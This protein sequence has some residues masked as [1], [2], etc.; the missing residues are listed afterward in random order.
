MCG[1]RDRDSDV[2]TRTVLSC[3]NDRWGAL[4]DG[5]REAREAAREAQWYGTRLQTRLTDDE[6]GNALV[7][8]KD[9]GG[10]N[11]C[12]AGTRGGV[13]TGSAAESGGDGS[14]MSDT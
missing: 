6:G 3:P 11:T 8:G 2:R 7:I 9:G 13:D 1:E 10:N 5:E 12:K 4:G 14:D